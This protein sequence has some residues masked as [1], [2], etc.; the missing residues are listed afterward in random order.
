[1]AWILYAMHRAWWPEYRGLPD[2]SGIVMWV[3]GG[4]GKAYANPGSALWEFRDI[5]DH[6]NSFS[7]PNLHYA[8]EYARNF[9]S[10]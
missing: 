8:H 1:M 3:G 5:I 2:L 9:H 4:E 10:V 6:P 7:P